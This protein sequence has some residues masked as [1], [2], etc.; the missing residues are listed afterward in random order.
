MIYTMFLIIA[1]SIDAMSF[2]FAQGF[3]KKYITILNCLIMTIISTLLFTIPLYLSSFVFKYFNE[4]L[5]NIINGIVLIILGIYY[6]V[7]NL[8]TSKNRNLEKNNVN[9]EHLC[10]KNC[11]L[12][13]F[14]ISLDAIF[15]TFL[16]GY[17]IPDIIFAIIFFFCFTFISILL[18]NRISLKISN[19][20]SLHISWI[21][22]II[23]L[24]IGTLK[25]F[26]I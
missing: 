26:G 6:L 20:T 23:F 18:P 21:S 15:T 7:K 17:S 3:Q 10:L 5:C 12:S 4:Q 8:T 25:S 11:I 14:P 22:G 9:I 13:T 16:N 24:I 2:G 1:I 19:K